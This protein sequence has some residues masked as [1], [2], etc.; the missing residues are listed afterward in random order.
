MFTKQAID[1][2]SILIEMEKNLETNAKALESINSVKKQEAI[3]LLKEAVEEFNKAGLAKLAGHF[4]DTIEQAEKD[5]K[6]P[7]AM[8][9][10]MGENVDL[11]DSEN[12]EQTEETGETTIEELTIEE[13]ENITV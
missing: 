8:S 13:P 11:A 1:F 10:V 3:N 7:D 2:D 5:T 6:G 9:A 12:T 4:L